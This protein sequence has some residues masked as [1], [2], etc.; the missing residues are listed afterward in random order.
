[1]N[2]RRSPKGVG[3]SQLSDQG[4]NLRTGLW[5]PLRFPLETQV[6]TSRK[7]LRGQDATVSGLT[8]IKAWRQLFQALERHNQNN[9]S[10][11]S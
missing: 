8:M 2:A 4:L 1:M 10:A 11:F 3:C 7:P 6:Q 9:R 5:A